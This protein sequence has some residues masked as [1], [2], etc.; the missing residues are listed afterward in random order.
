[1]G[2]ILVHNQVRL[3]SPDSKG[4][5]AWWRSRPKSSCPVTADGDP[6]EAVTA[7]TVKLPWSELI[8]SGHP[9]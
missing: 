8:F 2:F 9:P 1:M 3:S 7:G 5:R 6:T 4:F